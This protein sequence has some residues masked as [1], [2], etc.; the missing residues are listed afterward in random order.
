MLSSKA[1]LNL[2]VGL[3]SLISSSRRKGNERV[4]IRVRFLMGKKV[5]E[6]KRKKRREREGGIPLSCSS[7]TNLS[8]SLQDSSSAAVL[9][10]FT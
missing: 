1:L 3:F 6:Q 7:M 10:Y 4:G 9:R 5:E 8:R 2:Y